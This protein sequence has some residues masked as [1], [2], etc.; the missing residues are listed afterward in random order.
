MVK[1]YFLPVTNETLEQTL[2]ILQGCT[3]VVW[4]NNRK[5]LNFNPSEDWD[6]RYLILTTT[7]KLLFWKDT[8][9]TKKEYYKHTDCGI[10]YGVVSLEKFIKKIKKG[11]N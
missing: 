4:V 1:E 3:D 11:G 2:A 6:T 8:R 9:V 10:T 5:P 7:G